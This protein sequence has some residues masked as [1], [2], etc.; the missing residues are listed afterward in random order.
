MET[1]HKNKTTINAKN[2]EM[3]FLQLDELTY[4]QGKIHDGE[5]ITTYDG[6]Y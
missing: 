1:K 5:R 4:F 2:A 6:I 3:K